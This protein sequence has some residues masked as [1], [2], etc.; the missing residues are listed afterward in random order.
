[1][2]K[3]SPAASAAKSWDHLDIVD[4][5]ID[6]AADTI[7]G[8]CPPAGGMSCDVKKRCHSSDECDNDSDSVDNVMNYLSSGHCD[9]ADTL[10]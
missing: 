2:D 5:Y 6:D 9:T 8:C 10:V 3:L 4:F 7:A 1:M